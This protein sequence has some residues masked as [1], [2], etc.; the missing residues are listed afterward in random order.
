MRCA[1]STRAARRRAW[2][3]PELGW[4]ETP[5]IARAE[6]GAGVGGPCIVEE[7]DATCLLPPGASARLDGYGNIDIRLT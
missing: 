7:Y 1:R 3:G 2:F 5:V 6:I 4:L